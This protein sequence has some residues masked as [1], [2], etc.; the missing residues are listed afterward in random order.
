MLALERGYHTSA[1]AYFPF[2]EWIPASQL[3]TSSSSGPSGRTILSFTNVNKSEA[4]TG[5]FIYMS[6]GWYKVAFSLLATNT[7]LGNHLTLCADTKSTPTCGHI[8]HSITIT[9]GNFTNNNTWTN[10]TMNIYLDNVFQYVGLSA[11]NV[12]WNGTLEV[13]GL[14]ILQSAPGSPTFA[15]LMAATPP[16]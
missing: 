14:E 7:S 13:R 12:T 6:P 15:P 16:P 3:W 8:S 9:G 10:V 2:Q 4:W 1:R 5:P 11:M